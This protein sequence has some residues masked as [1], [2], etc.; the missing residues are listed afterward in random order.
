MTRRWRP[1]VLAAALASL[2]TGITTWAGAGWAMRERQPPTLHA[3]VHTRLDLSVEQERRLAVIEARFAARRPLLEA[4][5]R[6]ANR[7]LGDAIAV[8]AGDTP[9]VQTAV[10]GFHKAMGDLQKATIA[11]VFEMRSVLTPTQARVFD[12]AV[13]DALYD[14]AG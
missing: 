11:H 13:V 1:L 14:D 6:A 3:I 4:R 8:S 12:V 2:V 10:D 7:E 9:R 5:I